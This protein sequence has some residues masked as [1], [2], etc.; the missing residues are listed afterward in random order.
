MIARL[1][2]SYRAVRRAD[3][4]P[5]RS[6]ARGPGVWLRTQTAVP[7][8][9]RLMGAKIFGM[10]RRRTVSYLVVL[11]D[12]ETGRLVGLVDGNL[13]T[14]YRTAA[15]SALAVD[16]LAPV[17]PTALGVL[18]S[19]HEARAHV[20]AIA[21]I[22]PLTS[23]RMFSPT[24]ENCQRAVEELRAELHIECQA[25][26]SA[27]EAV[28]ESD[29]VVAAARSRGEQPIL[30][31]S[32]L[33]RAKTIVSIGSTLPEQREIDVSVVDACDLIVCDA[34]EEVV[35]ETGDMRAAVAAGISFEHKIMALTD[36]LCGSSAAGAASGALTMFKS[37]GAGLQDIIVAGL[38][39][40][41]ALEQGLGQPIDIPLLEKG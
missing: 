20:R 17:G 15:T 29:I 28:S 14:A 4:S 18:G 40:E 8:A 22:R 11:L 25:V 36:L 7:G 12:Q 9:S 35:N 24:P 37:V 38:A 31:G 21:S 13:V 2:E 1:G 30:Y 33:T 32:W 16:S 39:L 3:S 34:L 23:L 10:G 5:P 27:Q 26:R 6:V 41:R 19:G